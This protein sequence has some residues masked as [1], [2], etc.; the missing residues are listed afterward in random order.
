MYNKI[1]NP[2]TGRQVS[3]F[4]KLGKKILKNYINMIGG[5]PAMIENIPNFCANMTKQ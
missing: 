5:A 2:V 3:I 1:I 4:G